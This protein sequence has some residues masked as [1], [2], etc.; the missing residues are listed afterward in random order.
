MTFAPKTGG[1]SI[2][3][4]V[5]GLTFSE[6][7]TADKIDE[8]AESKD[9]WREFLPRV[10]RSSGFEFTIDVQ[11]GISAPMVTPAPG[12]IFD[13]LN[14]DGTISWRL[15]VQQN[16]IY[17]NC[18]DYTS[19]TEIRPRA[20]ELLKT[21]SLLLATDTGVST[22]VLQYV[23]IW[24]WASERNGYDLRS[25]LRPEKVVPGVFDKGP[26]WHQHFGWFRP[27]DAM[28]GGRILERFH[29]DAVDDPSTKPSVKLDGFLSFEPENKPVMGGAFWQSPQVDALFDGLHDLNKD[30]VRGLLTEDMANRIGLNG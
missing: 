11:A 5:F 15:N 2:A 17:V 26:N 12:A 21:A 9:S 23:D 29:L 7:F 8:L 3:E 27:S 22:I 6:P 14:P 20:M 10:G 4:V 28:G 13:R 16:S 25:L 18:L 1:H 19:W 30:I 24:E